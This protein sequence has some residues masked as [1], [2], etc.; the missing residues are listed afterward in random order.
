MRD[1]RIIDGEVIT[2]ESPQRAKLH[3]FWTRFTIERTPR[4]RFWH[5]EVSTDFGTT[6]TRDKTHYIPD[7]PSGQPGVMRFDPE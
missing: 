6:W 5:H 4:G 1:V 2:L 3:S 7:E